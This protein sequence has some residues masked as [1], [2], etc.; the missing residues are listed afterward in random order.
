MTLLDAGRLRENLRRPRTCVR[1]PPDSTTDDCVSRGLY[2]H[3]HA[4]H[5]WGNATGS[6]P[7]IV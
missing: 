3:V 6:K 1:C 7:G 4:H 2:I 5:L